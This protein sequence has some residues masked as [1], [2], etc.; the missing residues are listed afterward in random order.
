MTEKVNDSDA[1]ARMREIA[2]SLLRPDP[3]ASDLNLPSPRGGSQ[4]LREERRAELLGRIG[5]T[6]WAWSPD[7]P[8]D[9]KVKALTIW[10]LD[11]WDSDPLDRGFK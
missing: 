3:G 11:L 4:L 1:A 10:F 2:E 8:F 7:R 9:H 5:A 6:D